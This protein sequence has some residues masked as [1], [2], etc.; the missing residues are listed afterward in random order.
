MTINWAAL[1]NTFGVS[2]LITL[3]VVAAFALGISALSR[4]EA[5]AGGPRGAV[6]L[7]TAVLCFGACAAAVGYGLYL[8]S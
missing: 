5:L 2:L 8:L 6:A 1:G 7:S 3:G 4:R